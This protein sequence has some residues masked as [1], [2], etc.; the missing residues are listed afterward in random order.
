MAAVASQLPYKYLDTTVIQPLPATCTTLAVVA[1]AGHISVNAV[2]PNLLE[3]E[4]CF[5]SVRPSLREVEHAASE[6]GLALEV[7][8][9]GTYA[10]LLWGMHP[11]RMSLGPL[12]SR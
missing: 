12:M 9:C 4:V 8:W 5:S 6:S 2:P 1:K 10:T 11:I 7:G 3:R